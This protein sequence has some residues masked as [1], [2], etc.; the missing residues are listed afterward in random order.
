MELLASL[1]DV[2]ASQWR[3]QEMKGHSN[4]GSKAGEVSSDEHI[5]DIFNI[6][7]DSQINTETFSVLQ[8]TCFET[9]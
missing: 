4:S 6:Q 5:G 9:S 7:F 1:G 2:T 3:L 8:N